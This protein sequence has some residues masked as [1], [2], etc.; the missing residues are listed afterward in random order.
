MQSLA[1]F[2]APDSNRTLGIEIECFYEG[3]QCPERYK[4]HGFFYATDDSSIQCG[5]GNAGIEFVSQPLP[6]A[7]L[8]KEIV[9]LASRKSGWQNAWQYNDTCG[10][11]IHV[12]RKWLSE[13]R[14]KAIFAFMNTLSYS[15]QRELFGRTGNMY[16][17]Y[18]KKWGGIRYL[19][20]NSSN[21]Q[22]FEFRVFSSGDAAWCCYCVDM[23]VYLINNADH[24]NID[25]VMAFKDS[26]SYFPR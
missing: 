22:T 13:K 9:K 18:G 21:K 16:C 3:T 12:S 2:R 6:A 20:I 10:V 25:A 17:R 8:K 7:W 11:H 4:H 26:H 14:A 19:P 15:E 5:W 1:K 24:L 23:V